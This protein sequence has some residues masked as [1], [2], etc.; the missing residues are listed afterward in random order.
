MRAFQ[1]SGSVKPDMQPIKLAFFGITD[2]S[3][4]SVEGSLLPVNFPRGTAQAVIVTMRSIHTNSGCHHSG[5]DPPSLDVP[6]LS[7]PKTY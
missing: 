7:H 3:E 6:A 5:L 1:G 4:E 2:S